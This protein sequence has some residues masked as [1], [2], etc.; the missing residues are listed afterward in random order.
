PWAVLC[1][2]P[3]ITGPKKVGVRKNPDGSRITGA[4]LLSSEIVLNEGDV[5]REAPTPL[6]EEDECLL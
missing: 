6:E 2:T 4:V 3:D 5:L 1:G